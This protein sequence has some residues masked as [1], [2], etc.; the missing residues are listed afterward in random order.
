MNLFSPRVVGVGMDRRAFL[1]ATG[2]A[3]GGCLGGPRGS[4]EPD[5]EPR[6]P[7]DGSKSTTAPSGAV[8]PSPSPTSPSTSP[9]GGVVLDDVLV[10]KAVTYESS[11]GSGGV[12]AEGGRQYVVASVRAD[13]EL[14]ESAFAF[15]TDEGSWAPGLPDGAGSINYAVA[16][17]EGGPVGRR[18]GGN[19]SYLGFAVPSP[20]SPSNP[21][22][23]YS[24]PDDAEWP[25]SAESRNR[26]AAPAPRFELDRLVVPD[27][28]ALGDTLS[29]SL[30][31]RNV[32]ETAGRF[33]AALYWPTKRVADDDE[34]YVV[35]R[36]AAAGDDV[37]ASVEVDTRH[38]TDEAERV[39]LSVRGHVAAEREV[40]VRVRSP[41]TAAPSSAS[42][43]TV[44]R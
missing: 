17:H 41:G 16:G 11:M 39:T 23:R 27:E 8:S 33:L 13:R 15:E 2:A 7:V 34:A 37:T 38:T 31:A 44:V 25:L 36:E 28:V 6:S 26:L 10:R 9:V 19:R 21:R 32:S 4:G 30:S 22:I 29:V 1:A 5:D 18:L 40:R 14:S 20:L 35:E 3:L 42:L 43:P 12:L 24:G